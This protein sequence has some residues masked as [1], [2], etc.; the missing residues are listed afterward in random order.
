M[1]T[2]IEIPTDLKVHIIIGYM[3]KLWY[4]A[5]SWVCRG[6]VFLLFY[7][8]SDIPNFTVFLYLF[9]RMSSKCIL[10]LKFANYHRTADLCLH[11]Q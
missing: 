6:A 7:Y 8:V 9:V 2:T 10:E 3:D 5:C 4:H 11:M 1:L